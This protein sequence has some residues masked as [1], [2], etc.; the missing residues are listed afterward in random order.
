MTQNST[1]LNL[2]SLGD[3]IVPSTTSPEASQSGVVNAIYVDG[4]G[5][6][7]V[8]ISNSPILSGTLGGLTQDYVSISPPNG[9]SQGPL[10]PKNY[11]PLPLIGPKPTVPTPEPIVPTLLPQYMGPDGVIQPTRM[12]SDREVLKI[13]QLKL[14][15]E[16]LKTD[17]IV[18]RNSILGL[19]TVRIE[20]LKQVPRDLEAL[21]ENAKE[22]DNA[23]GEIYMLDR[24]INEMEHAIK[25]IRQAADKGYPKDSIMPPPGVED[26]TKIGTADGKFVDIKEVLKEMYP[27]VDPYP[28]DPTLIA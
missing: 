18:W 2:E 22:I 16:D 26:R 17:L 25:S 8:N 4:T 9:P 19:F 10:T 27:P 6:G 11:G 5:D 13:I 20:L 12:L 14:A 21:N 15:I 23:S 28:L 7:G 3:R 1:R 24:K